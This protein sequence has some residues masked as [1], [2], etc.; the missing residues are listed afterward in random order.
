[1]LFTNSPYKVVPFHKLFSPKVGEPVGIKET[2]NAVLIKE[3][4]DLIFYPPLPK[5]YNNVLTEQIIEINTK[6]N[7]GTIYKEE[8]RYLYSVD[9]AHT[10]GFLGLIYDKK[11][12]SFIDE[13]A[14]L[15]VENLGTSNYINFYSPPPA[16]YL[17]GVTLS[18]VTIGADG[19]FY[20]FFHE[21]LPKLFFCK[22]VLPHIDHFLMNGDAVEWKEKWLRHI[23]LDLEK[24]IWINNNSHYHCKQLLFTNRLINDY[25]I[26]NWSLNAIRSLVKVN[27][28]F[29]NPVGKNQ[30]AIW[31]TRKNVTA[32]TILW[33]DELLTQFPAIKKVDIRNFSVDETIQLFKNATHIIGAHGAGLSNLLFCRPGTKVLELY[34]DIQKYHPCYFRISSLCGL[35]HYVAEVSFSETSGME[36]CAVMLKD[37]LSDNNL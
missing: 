5:S 35:D 10:I 8:T 15:W 6:Y 37:F 31:I 7:T 32:R 14:K 19:G 36:D 2:L 24:V 20:H 1:M 26:S 17:P 18:C 9:S 33:E 29:T 11:S 28:G 13:S 27:S 22:E 3:R 34:P 12:R 23:G 4:G 21:V 16:K 25:H 30:E